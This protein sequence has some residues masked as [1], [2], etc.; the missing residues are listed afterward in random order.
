MLR[1]FSTM[2][3]LSVVASVA[4]PAHAQW[5]SNFSDSVHQD[6]RRNTT[7]P[8]PF[9]QADRESVNLPFAL[10]VA[11][12]W[13]RQNLMS[14]YLFNENSPQLTKAGELKLRYI[15]TQMPPNRRTVF[16]QRGMTPE[17]TAARSRC[18]AAVGRTHGVQ[19]RV[20]R[21]GRVRS[22]KQ[23]MAGRRD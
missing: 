12:G 2:L 19:R 6:Y 9:Q 16:V 17:E 18:R 1:C 10:M 15:L 22:A 20:A 23:R 4:A 21:G 14:D 7:W 13:R 8:A 3:V 5:L 11:N